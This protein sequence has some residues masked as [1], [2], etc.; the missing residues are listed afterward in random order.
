MSMRRHVLS[1][2]QQARKRPDG[3]KATLETLCGCMSPI[4]STGTSLQIEVK[5]FSDGV[6]VGL[7]RRPNAQK[8]KRRGVVKFR[9]KPLIM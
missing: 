9:F 6:E 7:G 2:T 4:V 8:R 5:N 1:Y 3:W